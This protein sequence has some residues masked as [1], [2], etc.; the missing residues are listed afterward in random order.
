MDKNKQA[1]E[2]EGLMKKTKNVFSGESESY[3]QKMV[4]NLLNTIKSNDRK[5]FFCVLLKKINVKIKDDKKSKDAKELSEKISG[6][7]NQIYLP[8]K[9]FEKMA[10]TIILGIMSSNK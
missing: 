10:F 3:K 2:L 7:L 1:E 6:Y 5:E 9:D 8:S 4:F